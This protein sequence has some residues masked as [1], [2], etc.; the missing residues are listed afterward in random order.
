MSKIKVISVVVFILGLAGLSF[1]LNR[2]A[3]APA[4]IQIAHRMSP[5][6]RPTNPAARRANDL[7][8]P[9]T[10]TL[11]GLYSLTTVKVVVA[12]DMETNKFPHAIWKLVTDSNSV[13]VSTFN[14]GNPLRGMRPDIKGARPDPLEPGIAY[15]LIIVT[16]ANKHTQHDFTVTTNR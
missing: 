9:V 13:P 7:G 5:W 15:R 6:M 1:Y 2:D 12:A 11:N 10:F 4:T 3:F 14:Y 8:V 16:A